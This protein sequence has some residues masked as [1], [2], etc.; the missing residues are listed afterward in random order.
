MIKLLKSLSRI[1]GFVPVK[2][3]ESLSPLANHFR[4]WF[5]IHIYDIAEELASD[6]AHTTDELKADR[7]VKKDTKDNPG[8]GDGILKTVIIFVVSIVG[9]FIASITLSFVIS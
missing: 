5:E 1:K 8:T 7:D 6:P 3:E 2:P 9:L 4:G